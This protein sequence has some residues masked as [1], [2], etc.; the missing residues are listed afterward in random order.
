MAKAARRTFLV[1][2]VWATGADL[3]ELYSEERPAAPRDPRGDRR[4]QPGGRARPR[5][6][7]RPLVGPP[8]RGDPGQGREPSPRAD[9]ARSATT[10]LR[11]AAEQAGGA[12]RTASVTFES[13][14]GSSGSRPFA[15]AKR[16]REELARHDR[17]QRREQR[18]R[19]R[20]AREDVVGARDRPGRVPARDDRRACLARTLDGLDDCGQRRVVRGDRPHGEE[21]VERGNRP[22]GEVRRRRAARLRCGR[23]R[24]A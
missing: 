7:A 10:Q 19:R 15:R 2:P 11:R 9:A 18:R 5:A 16:P 23:S 1:K 24:G 21:R 8:A 4:P 13:P 6:R 3:D 12:Q 17:Q 20:G 22:V 14:R